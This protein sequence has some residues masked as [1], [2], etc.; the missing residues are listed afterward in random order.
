MG[1]SLGMI[2][3]ISAVQNA[4][5]GYLQAVFGF[6]TRFASRRSIFGLGHI[7]LGAS[8]LLTGASHNPSEL[9]ASRAV[10]GTAHSTHHPMAIPMISDKFPRSKRGGALALH[11]SAGNLGQ[12]LAPAIASPVILL[13]GWRT[14]LTILAIPSVILGALILT[15]LNSSDPARSEA[16]KEKKGTT[17]TRLFKN[18]DVALI[19][20]TQMIQ[21]GGRGFSVLSTYLPIYLISGLGLPYLTTGL[22]FSLY[23]M[24]GIVGPLLFGPLSDRMGRKR[25]LTVLMLGLL[26]V[27]ASLA[28]T[29]DIILVAVLLAAL[30]VI[31]FGIPSIL[32]TFLAD[33]AEP[34]QRD[35]AFGLYFTLGFGMGSIYNPVFGFLIDSYGFTSMFAAIMLLQT[36]GL[37]TISLTRQ[38]AAT[39][40]RQRP[41]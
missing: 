23:P 16:K 10:F 19:I 6:L 20:L 22:I 36:A 41:A 25:V 11:S 21:A 18:R 12:A 31:S 30:G 4:A 17:I 7:A 27:T 35:A 28:V 8:T 2:G 29:R 3:I 26:P 32:Q 9:I 37:A 38:A 39:I 1:L 5:S 14:A 13:F 34:E 24:G 40:Q 15:L 33:V